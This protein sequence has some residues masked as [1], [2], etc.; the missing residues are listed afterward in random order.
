MVSTL[1]YGEWLSPISTRLLVADSVRLGGI[2]LDGARA[3]WL[4]GRPSEG[5]RNVLVASEGEGVNC[6]VVPA[7]FNVR[8]RA[9]EYGGGAFHVDGGRIWFVNFDDQ[10]IY[11]CDEATPPRP[12]TAAGPW[13]Y[14]DMILD[15]SRG[16]LVCV[17]EDHSRVGEEPV[18]ALVS[19][20][21]TSGAVRVIAEGHDFY[22]SP[23][24]SA[25]AGRLAWIAWDHPDMPWDASA[26]WLAELNGDG[27]PASPRRIAGGAGESVFQPRFGNDGA[28]FYVCD[29]QGWW[30]LHRWHDGDTRCV[31]VMQAEFG[32]PQWQFGMSTYGFDAA[33]RIVCCYCRGGFWHLGRLSTEDGTLEPIDAGFTDIQAIAVEGEKTLVVAG[34]ATRAAAVALIEPASGAVSVLRESTKREFDEDYVSLPEAIEFATGN[35]ERAHAF[36]YPPRNPHFRAPADERP[37][38]IVIGHGGPTSAA[39]STLSLAIQYWTSRGFAVLDVNYR[40]S[41]GYGRAYRDRLRGCWG[42]VDV[43]DCVNGALH[44][45]QAGRADGTRLVIRGSSA[46]GYTTLAALAFHDVFAAG[47][48]YYGVSDLEALARD[49]HKFESRYLDCLIGPY[50]EQRQRYVDRSPIHAVDRLSCPVIFFQGLEDEVVPPSQS[51]RMVEALRAK[52]IAVAYLAF[53]GEQHGFR[54]AETIERT[55]QAELCFYARVFGFTPADDLPELAIDNL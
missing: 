10:R 51:E 20:D 32:R 26:L 27:A 4:E 55:L 9:H 35:G 31:L 8:T 13:R 11:Y 50:P 43:E 45:A 42:I 3:Y 38:L 5:G 40:G 28:L 34:S 41:T 33:G 29:P 47:A 44:L 19:V 53:E 7:P 14:A 36:Y 1:P 46:G 21:I 15:G 48:S 37:P 24:M 30:N 12:L 22:A 49:T 54:R 52:G 16:R 18:N 17:R 39:S 2:A 23:C 6:D 25:D